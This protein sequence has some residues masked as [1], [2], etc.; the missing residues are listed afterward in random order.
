[1]SLRLM[2][3]EVVRLDGKRVVMPNFSKRALMSAETPSQKKEEM[4]KL[5]SSDDGL[6]E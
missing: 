4:M 5:Q 3:R 1:M 6:L 2:P